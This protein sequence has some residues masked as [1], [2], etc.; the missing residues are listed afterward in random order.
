MRKFVL[1]ILF[2]LCSFAS[3]AQSQSLE[4]YYIAHDRTTPVND[5]CDRLEEVFETAD[6]YE[7]YAV[8]FYLPNYDDPIVVKVNLPGDNRNDFKNLISDLRLKAAHEIYADVDYSNI[9]DLINE[10]DFIDETGRPKYSSVLFCWYVNPDFWQFLNNEELIGA[11]YF[12]LELGR[13]KGYVTTQVWH[14]QG[15]GL[16]V[17]KKYPFGTKNL[18]RDMDF[19]LYQY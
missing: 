16:K 3:F 5:L 8:I 9:V 4:F 12:N 6:Q 17:D 13:Y 15:D 2:A 7:D 19:I 18:C 10:H 14:S 11:L 1:S